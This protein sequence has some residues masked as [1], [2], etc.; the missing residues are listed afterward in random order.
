MTGF[1]TVDPNIKR[2]GKKFNIYV[3]T[4]RNKKVDYRQLYVKE[5]REPK[6]K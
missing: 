3:C 1:T 6:K 5:N 2:K 4:L